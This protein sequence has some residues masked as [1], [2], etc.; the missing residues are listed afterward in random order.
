MKIDLDKMITISKVNQN[1][2]MAARLTDEL[3]L[4][5]IMKNSQPKFVLMTFE[6]F[7]EYE[8]ERSKKTNTE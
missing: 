1:F 5:T 4:L 7:E 3:G 6:R 2:S 8:L